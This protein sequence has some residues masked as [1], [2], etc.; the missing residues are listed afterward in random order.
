MRLNLPQLLVVLT[1]NTRACESDYGII[2]YK[3][4]E[5]IIMNHYDMLQEH[6]L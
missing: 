2:T 6:C 5:H 3:L 4:L 1:F